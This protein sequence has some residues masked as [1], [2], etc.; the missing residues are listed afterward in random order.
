MSATD[1][2]IR[3]LNQIHPMD[4]WDHDVVDIPAEHGLIPHSYSTA[5]ITIHRG[6]NFTRDALHLQFVVTTVPDEYAQQEPERPSAVVRLRTAWMP[7][8]IADVNSGS[9]TD[10]RLMKR[11]VDQFLLQG[12]NW[13]RI[14]LEHLAASRD[15]L[16]VLLGKKP[17]I[18]TPTKRLDIRG[19]IRNL[20]DRF[21]SKVGPVQAE[22]DN[23]RAHWLLEAFFR[24]GT[25][26]HFEESHSNA[27]GAEMEEATAEA[28]Q[29]G[30]RLAEGHLASGQVAFHKLKFHRGEPQ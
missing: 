11:N 28:V 26:P 29:L 13:E 1:K 6:R 23:I 27:R 17:A 5:D 8:V 19:A 10:P 25:V 3:R 30:T 20:R 15:Q 24:E 22:G 21:A 2:L 12:G 18:V 16:A 14:L 4:T 9:E 7:A